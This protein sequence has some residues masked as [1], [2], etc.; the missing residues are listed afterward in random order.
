MAL[1][2]AI[3]YL[4]SRDK[5][6]LYYCLYMVLSL[7][8]F[9]FW[10]E[11][12]APLLGAFRSAQFEALVFHLDMPVLIGSYALYALFIREFLSLETSHRPSYIRLTRIAQ[13][14]LIIISIDQLFYILFSYGLPN[15]YDSVFIPIRRLTLFI[16]LLVSGLAIYYIYYLRTKLSKLVIIGTAI[17]CL[18]TST[19]FIVH[20]FI[21]PT[22]TTL[23]GQLSPFPNQIGF[24]LEIFF[25][26]SSLVFRMKWLQDEKNRSH[27]QLLLQIEANQ[28]LEREKNEAQKEREVNQMKARFYT[29]I[30]H[31][32]RTPL[33]IIRGMNE[34]PDSQKKR[35]LIRRNVDNLLQLVNSLLDLSKLEEG[36]LTPKYSQIDVIKYINYLGE[37][38]QSWAEQKAIALTVYSEIHELWMDTDREKLGQIIRNLLSNALK[39]T[40]EKGKIILHIAQAD[41]QLILK[42][43]DSGEGIHPEDIPH[44][45]DRFYQGKKELN[46]Q[47]VGTGIGL[48]LVKDL[49]T[50]L[51]GS[52][53]VSSNPDSGTVFNIQLPITR[54][55]EKID[56]FPIENSFT[57]HTLSEVKEDENVIPS[58][59]LPTLLLIEDNPDL[60]TYIT[61]LLSET[62]RLLVAT[63]GN[64]GIQKALTHIPDI[65]V[66]DVMMPGKD[67]YEVVQTLKTDKRSSHIPII[68]LTAKAGQENKNQG[69][70]HG[71]DAYLLK[72]F[73]EKELYIRLEQLIQLRQRLQH[74]YATYRPRIKGE[75]Q[76]PDERF[77]QEAQ[78]ILS[79]QS[80]SSLFGVED[81]A[82]EMYLSRTQLY[83][84]IKALT[85]KTPSQ[86]LRSFRLQKARELLMI[87]E[88][89]V[90]EIAYKVGFSDPSYF[91]RS[92]SQEFGESP[93]SY[94]N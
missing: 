77:L 53:T 80:E 58:Q 21:R 73:S 91:S 25:F 88:L 20:L 19:G 33:T 94:R 72:P 16:S 67:G 87:P 49:V 8:F 74:V 23:L 34:Q 62:Y 40:P 66:S 29:L 44:I 14:F 70:A 36:F 3:Q 63:D 79:T 47:H 41:S 9:F 4:I 22:A 7:L 93:N 86:F 71:A 37:S 6:Y 38:F 78:E 64:E 42:V 32:F 24:L 81:W 90:A 92:F 57:A 31:E 26:S 39:F 51:N 59:E 11:T 1:I 46:A 85:G 28:Q 17:L 55:A 83:R 12:F 48:A 10:Y 5:A 82:K 89:H 69:L 50:L 13:F 56:V 60:V 18:S 15:L 35:N 52:I 43:Q 68:L 76:S 27:D 84:K 45:F 75:K 61:Q 65:I 30:T 54:K 2:S